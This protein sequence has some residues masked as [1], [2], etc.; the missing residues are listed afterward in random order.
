MLDIQGSQLSKCLSLCAQPPQGGGGTVL[1]GVGQQLLLQKQRAAC[2]HCALKQRTNQRKGDMDA[3]LKAVFQRQT[4]WMRHVPAP[5][6]TAVAQLTNDCTATSPPKLSAHHCVIPPFNQKQSIG[7]PSPWSFN[8]LRASKAAHFS[9]SQG[10]HGAA[11]RRGMQPLRPSHYW[12]R[13]QNSSSIQQPRLGCLH[14]ATCCW[15]Q[16]VSDAAR[17]KFRCGCAHAPARLVHRACF[18]PPSAHYTSSPS[19]RT[20]A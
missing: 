8:R 3:K 2:G 9:W 10:C 18:V 13:Q 7:K 6:Y 17:S 12:H 16:E 11:A 1:C 4:R 14:C 20:H 15:R 5:S 19:Q